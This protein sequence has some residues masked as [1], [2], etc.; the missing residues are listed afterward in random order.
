M[1]LLDIGGW[2]ASA[3]LLKV[4][5][6][7]LRASSWTVGVSCTAAAM[8]SRVRS[9]WVGPRPPRSQDEVSALQG[10]GEP[11]S[12]HGQ[13]VTDDGDPL[14]LDA[15]RWQPRRHPGGV[16]ICELA[17]EQFR[18]NR[19][20][21]GFHEHSPWVSC[22]QRQ[23]PPG[24]PPGSL[25]AQRTEGLMACQE[26][27]TGPCGT[28]LHRSVSCPRAFP[29]ASVWYQCYVVQ[30]AAKSTAQGVTPSYGQRE[31]W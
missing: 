21:F 13:T 10:A 9:S 28:P 17:H 19:E 15:Q 30:S 18:T 20:D 26:S 16:R 24:D 23:Q 7:S 31:G 12:E 3:T 11:C 14:Q 25:A 1:G 8:A 22:R 5:L 27:A 2:H 29:L 6:G 4:A